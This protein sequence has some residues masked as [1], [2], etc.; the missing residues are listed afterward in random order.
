MV[1]NEAYAPPPCRRSK[2][3]RRHDA[4]F[5]HK[6][7]RPPIFRS[8]VLF[9]FSYFPMFLKT[10]ARLGLSIPAVLH[11]LRNGKG[12]FPS[13]MVRH[14]AQGHIYPRRHAGG[15]VKLPVPCPAGVPLP[16]HLLPHGHG[17]VKGPLISCGTEPVQKP[18]RRRPERNRYTPSSPGTM[19]P[20]PF[21]AFPEKEHR[22]KVS[23]SRSLLE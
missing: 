3:Q 8:A 16:E 4:P 17:P 15:S 23:S 11:A 13:E 12:P 18:R 14:K 5:L 21:G 20:W 10:P 2:A 1:P 7:R 19:H 6:K 22:R 9:Y